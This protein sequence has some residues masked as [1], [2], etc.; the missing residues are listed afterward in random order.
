MWSTKGMWP[1]CKLSDMGN[2]QFAEC[3][4]DLEAR[5]ISLSVLLQL[6]PGE[7]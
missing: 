7:I 5:L 4:C 3:A 6:L 1:V 2:L